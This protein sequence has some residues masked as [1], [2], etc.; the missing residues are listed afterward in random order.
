V[1][2]NCSQDKIHEIVN[3]P[4]VVHACREHLWRTFRSGELDPG[5]G[6]SASQPPTN[7]SPA[8]GEDVSGPA[9]PDA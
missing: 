2:R 3:D 1:R 6:R 4:E 7:G 9:S 5:R 8:D